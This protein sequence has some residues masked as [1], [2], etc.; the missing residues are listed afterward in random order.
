MNWSLWKKKKAFFVPFILSEGNFFN[1][2]VLSQCTVYWIHFQYINTFTYQ[3][4]LLYMVFCLF[5]KLSKAVSVSL[6]MSTKGCSRFFKICLDLELFA[7][8]KRELVFFWFLQITKDLNKIKKIAKT[9][10]WSLVSKNVY[11]IPAKN[12]QL[13]SWSSTKFSIFLTKNLVSQK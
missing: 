6:I 3:K 13:G 12:I 7:K 4:T 10:S 9:L 5:L 11:K 2:C 1:I 8:I